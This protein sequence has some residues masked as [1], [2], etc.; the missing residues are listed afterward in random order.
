MPS[1]PALD[2]L[3]QHAEQT[4][5]TAQAAG[6]GWQAS[7]PVLA[8]ELA[9]LT[10]PRRAAGRRFDLVFLLGVVTL[11]VLTGVR[12]ISGIR[13]W[14]TGAPPAVLTALARG[15]PTDL[16]AASTLARLDGDTLDDILARYI[17]AVLAVGDPP[18]LTATEDEDDAVVVTKSW[19]LCRSGAVGAVCDAMVMTNRVRAGGRGCG[20]REL[21]CCRTAFVGSEGVAAQRV[22]GRAGTCEA[23]PPVRSLPGG[24]CGGRLDG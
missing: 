6:P 23:A 20:G 10:D 4:L 18:V 17:A 16:S 15:G 12:T 8:E 7:I 14:A 19:D 22:A 21:M 3:G 13:R 11:S 5:T 24:G 1:S 9:A 2:R